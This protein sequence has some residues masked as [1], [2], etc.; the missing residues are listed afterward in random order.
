MFWTLS[1]YVLLNV[2][3]LSSTIQNID[4]IYTAIFLILLAVPVLLNLYL[5]IPVFLRKGNYFAYILSFL[6]QLFLFA[7]INQLMFGRFVDI[8]FPGYFFISYYSYGDLLKFFLVFLGITTLLQLSKE[9]FVLN[10][11]RQRMLLLEKEKADAELKAL[12]NQVNPHFLFNSLNLIYSLVIHK[13]KES[14]E[15]ILKLSDILRYVIYRSSESSVNLEQEVQLIRNYIDLQRFRVGKDARISFTVSGD[16]K[17]LSIAP[18]LLLPLVE[19]GFKHGIKGDVDKTFLIIRL[20]IEDDD[21]LFSVENNKGMVEV[22]G[23][24]TFGGVGLKN[25]QNRLELIY[26][27]N[28]SFHVEDSQEAFKVLLGIRSLSSREENR[29]NKK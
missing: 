5:F 9:W 1:Y 7:W 25:I 28:H 12:T 17:Y 2:F 14:P 13:R 8:L 18:M 11:A 24:K 26:P 20:N 23:E 15:A 16:T 21:I 22:D 4:F 29:L 3:S 10:T 19:N 6:V 27:G